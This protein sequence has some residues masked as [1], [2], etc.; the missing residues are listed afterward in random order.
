MPVKLR[1]VPGCA[2][3][4]LSGDFRG[5]E[6]EFAN[7]RRAGH[8]ALAGQPRLVLDLARV[9]FLDSQTLGLLVELLRAAQSRGGEVVLA[10]VAER[11]ARW[12]GLSGLD[13]VFRVIPA[14]Q[15]LDP[16][17]LWPQGAAPRRPALE[18]LNIERLVGELQSALGA[19]DES[20]MPSQSGPVDEAV[21]AEIER[22][23]D[24]EDRP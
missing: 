6:Q 23:L 13:R 21:L 14:G 10:A 15:D 19:A 20:G 17:K 5:G 9:A 1:N 16:E 24:G 11:A 18:A 12:L 4:E 8:Q 2:I 3:L 22:L 7:L